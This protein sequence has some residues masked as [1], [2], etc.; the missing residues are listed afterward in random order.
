MSVWSPASRKQRPE[1]RGCPDFDPYGATLIESTPE[2][3]SVFTLLGVPLVAA[4]DGER[5]ASDEDRRLS[6]DGAPRACRRAF[7]AGLAYWDWRL[8]QS[9]ISPPDAFHTPA[10]LSIC[11][12]ASS[13]YLLRQGWPITHG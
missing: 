4:V 6:G 11:A 2:R 13:R 8:Y 3:G 7:H 10:Y 12:S 9:M 5:V 1:H